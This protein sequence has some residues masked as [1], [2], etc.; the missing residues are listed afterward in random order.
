LLAE[1]RQLAGLS[2]EK[3]A[4]EIGMSTYSIIA[5]ER[6]QNRPNAEVL[7]AIADALD[8]NVDDFYRVAA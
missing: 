7:G 8:C 5:Y 4:R 1:R 2:R 6:K 3:V